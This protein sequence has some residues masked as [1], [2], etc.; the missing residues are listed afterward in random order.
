MGE[1]GGE[2]GRRKR[3]GEKMEGRDV[4]RRAEEKM[5]GRDV[6]RRRALEKKEGGARGGEEGG[7]GIRWR[8]RRV[9]EEE[10]GRKIC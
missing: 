8:L 9:E 2:E 4:R 7:L 5:E 1:N 3:A 6:R 10:G